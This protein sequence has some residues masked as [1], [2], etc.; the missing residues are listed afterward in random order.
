MLQATWYTAAINQCAVQAD[1]S[2]AVS[3]VNE[4]AIGAVLLFRALRQ[5]SFARCR[6]LTDLSLSRLVRASCSQLQVSA[7]MLWK[8]YAP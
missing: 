2:L 7:L 6:A 4:V 3:Q 8:A 1:V 5:V